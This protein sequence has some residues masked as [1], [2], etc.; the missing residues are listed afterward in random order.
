MKPLEIGY[1]DTKIT[2]YLRMI[3][4]EEEERYIEKFAAIP[5]IDPDRHTKR[6]E[7]YKD[8]LGEFSL[9]PPTINKEGKNGVLVKDASAVD[10]IQTYFKERSVENERIMRAAYVM[11]RSQLDPEVNFL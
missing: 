2:F 9:K 4:V 10:A 8:A 7:V 6:F 5:D 3:S 11:F 1:E